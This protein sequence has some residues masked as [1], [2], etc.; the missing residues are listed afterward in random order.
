[1]FQ[2]IL[3]RIL[4]FIPTLFVISLVVYTL[5]VYAP[6]D[7]VASMLAA[8][9][10]GTESMTDRV[11]GERAYMDMRER[12]NLHLPTFYFALSTRAHP[13]TLY[14]I[15][16]LPHVDN[17]NRLIH[18]YGNWEQINRYYQRIS[19]LEEFTYTLER[20]T[21]AP[22]A[23]T[24]IRENISRLY[25]VH[26]DATITQIF[27]NIEDRMSETYLEPQI[28]PE[29]E[30][31]TGE[32]QTMQST[33]TRWKNY[34]PSIHW[35]GFENR[36]HAWF[37][38]FLKFDFGISYQDRQ[39]I[40]RKIGSNIFWTMFI[41]FISIILTYLIA[42][43]L[44]IFSAVRKGS[45][46]DNVL[47]TFLFVLYSLP[48]FWV[49][50][51]LIIFLCQPDYLNIFPPF[52]VGD[53]EGKPFFEA[54]AIRTHHLILPLFCWTYGSLAFLSRQMRSGMLSVMNQDF[55]RT[56]RAK[57]LKENK[58]IWKHAFKN[59]LLPIITLFANVFPLM[60]SGSVVIEVIFTIPGMGKMLLDAMVF[61]DFPV[62]FTIVML[63]AFLTM[64][65]YLIADILYAVVDPR[66]TYS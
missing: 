24:R 47:T 51:L 17:L 45:K 62:V 6:G 32:Y 54:L 29:F 12:L 28:R 4:I 5:S 33:A 10:A 30:K 25:I 41:S 55:I 63:S 8:T 57:G 13:D 40:N 27:R 37:S 19:K 34:I 14:R 42:V 59:S 46:S 23:I 39:P 66:I 9:G 35:Y 49:A 61:K 18:Q 53:I 64:I 3:K 38:A 1:M 2:Y 44:G 65:G 22:M 16:R 15:P 43:P 36:Y 50:T 21:L 60:I 52:G 31:L 56:A 11:A 20:D 48:N 26:N 7:P 58:V